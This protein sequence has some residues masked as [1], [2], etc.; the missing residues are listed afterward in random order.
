MLHLMDGSEKEGRK[1]A[2]LGDVPHESV[3]GE[4]DIGW[5]M[6]RGGRESFCQGSRKRELRNCQTW[7]PV[8]DFVVD[9][10]LIQVPGQ[11]A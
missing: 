6:V 5:A 9:M 11:T 1:G 10:F 7:A 3:H 2:G 8:F 4:N